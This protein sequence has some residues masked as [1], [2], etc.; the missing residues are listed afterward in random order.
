MVVFHFFT[1]PVAKPVGDDIFLLKLLNRELWKLT[2]ACSGF[3]IIPDYM[4]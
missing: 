3:P 4:I 2:E 1:V